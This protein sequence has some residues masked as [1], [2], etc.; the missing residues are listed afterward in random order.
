[1]DDATVF[2]LL[3]AARFRPMLNAIITDFKNTSLCDWHPHDGFSKLHDVCDANMYL[4]YIVG[5]NQDAEITH[6]ELMADDC[7]LA[8]RALDWVNERLE[9]YDE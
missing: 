5:I 4:F 6:D 7:K 9:N 3:D 2:E 8:N 1:M